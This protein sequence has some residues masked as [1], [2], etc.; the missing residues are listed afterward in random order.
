MTAI[1]DRIAQQL[2]D[3]S[4]VYAQLKT[5]I[6]EDR[7]F[8]NVQQLY[9]QEQ[10]LKAEIKESMLSYAL[11]PEHK[12]KIVSTD[13]Q[14][15][16]KLT[17]TRDVKSDVF[18]ED[19]LTYHRDEF[20]ARVNKLCDIIYKAWNDNPIEGVDINDEKYLMPLKFSVTTTNSYKMGK[21]ILESVKWACDCNNVKFV[22]EKTWLDSIFTAFDGFKR[23]QHEYEASKQ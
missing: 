23:A 22:E 9:E 12:D 18:I 16:S 11:V 17:A 10:K 2:T 8:S 13:G 7:P 5:A 21:V 3:L 4:Q 6:D 20:I 15:A 14:T 19:M 1:E